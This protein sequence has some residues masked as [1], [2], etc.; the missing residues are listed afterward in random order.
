MTLS[1]DIGVD[2]DKKLYDSPDRDFIN[3]P[4]SVLLAISHP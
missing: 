3:S 4:V 2:K 1:A